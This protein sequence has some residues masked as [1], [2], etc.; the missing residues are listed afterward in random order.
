M[1]SRVCTQEP[2]EQRLTALCTKVPATSVRIH[3]S[4]R[5]FVQ[6]RLTDPL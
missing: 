6:S 5:L 2:V 1:G 3:E 4:T